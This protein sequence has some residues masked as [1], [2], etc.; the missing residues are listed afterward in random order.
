MTAI[1]KNKFRLKSAK[2]FIENFEIPESRVHILEALKDNTLKQLPRDIFG[3][4][5]EKLPDR[6]H[7]LF[8]GKPFGWTETNTNTNSSDE[9]NPPLPQDTQDSDARV[10]DEMLSL[11]KI[12]RGDVTLVIPRS[13]WR[14][15]TIYAQFDSD[16]KDLYHQPTPQKIQDAQTANA[17]AGNFYAL[18]SQF[19]LF[20]CVSNNNNSISTE[21][22]RRPNLTGPNSSVNGRVYHTQDNYVWQY[23]TTIKSGDA[24]KFLTDKWIPIKTLPEDSNLGDDQEHVQQNAIP[25]E[26]L[27]VDVDSENTGS[28][29]YTFSGKIV[30]DSNNPKKFHFVEPPNGPQPVLTTNAYTGYELRVLIPATETDPQRVIHNVITDYAIVPFRTLTL[31]Y[32]MSQFIT[33]GVE[34]SCQI[35]PLIRVYSDNSS[36]PNSSFIGLDPVVDSVSKRLVAVDV[37]N[38]GSNSSTVLLNV[39]QPALFSGSL[40]TLRPILAPRHGLGRDPESDLGAFFVMVSTQLRYDEGD[41]FMTSNDYRQLGILRDVR[42]LVKDQ[43]NNDIAVLTTEN[44]LN[45]TKIINLEFA[46]EEKLGTGQKGFQ[47]DELV[48]IYTSADPLVPIGHARVLQFVKNTDTGSAIRGK[49]QVLQ[50]SNT[51]YY[52]IKQGDI[53]KNSLGV[54][55]TVAKPNESDPAIVNEEFLKFHGDIL[56][57]ENRRPILR[58]VDQIE[59]IKTIIEF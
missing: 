58:S 42:K 24:V 54:E 19:D 10:W 46:S 48:D 41:D 14:P 2:S 4:I 28:F 20:I 51:N 44:T 18:N 1:I 23:I 39:N 49:L 57:L 59:D 26:L 16:D 45:A 52:P 21:E 17:K 53:I 9:L 29:L 56:Y 47:S 5:L 33:T 50:T 43:N 32:D 36:T 15:N 34:Y 37:V 12:I 8:I 31:E 40:P 35:V 22:P 27:R 25:G 55:A 7:Y 6:N 3:E 13:D 30:R 38:P 11:K